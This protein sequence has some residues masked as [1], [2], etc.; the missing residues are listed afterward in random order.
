MNWQQIEGQWQQLKG[1]IRSRWGKLT[2]DDLAFVGGQRDKLIGKIQ[3]RY[4]V[5]EEQ[6]KKE[7]DE[8]TTR[9]GARI[10]QIG[11]SSRP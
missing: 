8:W 3:E 1:D 6:A 11:R 9:V 10:D 2:N 5:L 7:V 4:G